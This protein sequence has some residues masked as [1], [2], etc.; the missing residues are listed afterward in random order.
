M[1]ND[2]FNINGLPFFSMFNVVFVIISAA[3]LGLVLFLVCSEIAKWA[4]N[5]SAPKI[6]A[7]AVVK[8]KR[9]HI[10]RNRTAQYFVTFEFSTGDRK[11]FNVPH[12]EY[13][14]LAEGDSG[15]IIFQGT[16]YIGFQRNIKT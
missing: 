16:R 5:N 11:E 3:F 12:E 8:S 6:S 9:M 10:S 1:I 7:E 4:R 14:L 13:G 2:D 15:I